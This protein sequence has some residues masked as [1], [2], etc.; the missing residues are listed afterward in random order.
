MDE[1]P[2]NFDFKEL[3]DEPLLRIGI[4]DSQEYLDF[5]VLGKFTI[6]DENGE[7]L[8]ESVGSDLKWRVKL[9]EGKPGKVKY[10]LVL[11]ES[12]NRKLVEEKLQIAQKIDE[13]VYIRSLGGNIYF[14]GRK[15]NN[16]TKYI[17]VAGDYPTAL[18]A[19]KDFK[20]FQPEFIPYV[21]QETTKL[22][23]GSLEVFDAE[24]E[25]SAEGNNCIRVVAEDINTKIKIFGVRRFDDVLQKYYYTDQV[26]NGIIE[27]RVDNKANLMAISE[28]PLEA[29]LKRV[30]YSEVGADLPLNFLK[31]F[32][33]V[34]RNE[35]MAR[36]HHS[37]LGDPFDFP[38][39]GHSLRYSGDD[40]EDKNIDEAVES[41]RGQVLLTQDHIRD[42]PFHLV[43]GGHTEDSAGF[44]ENDEKPLFA[45]GY[46]WKEK[47]KNFESLQKEK[48][49]KKWIESRPRVW[50]N[51]MGRE[52][53]EALEKYKKFFR[54]EVSYSRKELEEIIRK[55]TGEDIGTLF[56]IFPLSRGISGRLNE[57]ELLGSLRNH[58][59]KGHL[60]IR[61]SLDHE[62]LPSSCFIF[63]KELDDSGTPIMFNF[64]GAGQGHGV[65]LCKT[66][67]A[68]MALE[69]LS[70]EEILNHYF[71]DSDLKS[72]YEIDLDQTT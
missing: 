25:S 20:R 14:K 53:P 45:G 10:F 1:E 21:D 66:G 64:I 17:L 70:S 48:N 44:W 29:Y 36:I 63:D 57:I 27:F 41:T 34:C 56:D 62:I 7:N 59:I 26:Y 61:E 19:R 47:P 8:T 15:I 72:I 28:I 60:N 43:C 65:G 2:R 46:D 51:L 11:F 40:F 18:E 9:K 30:I 23:R 68:I 33:V 38:N 55:K 24:Y 67:A 16:N 69:G 50:C 35:A 54:W 31:S 49:I 4:F 52:I 6:Q 5:K 3:N 13:N 39:T 22:P 37:S 32:A 58:R 12:F 42:T 71:Q